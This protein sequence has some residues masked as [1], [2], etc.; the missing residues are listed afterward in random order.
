M[1]IKK[2]Y[3]SEYVDKKIRKQRTKREAKLLSLVKKLGIPVPSIYDLDML[4]FTLILEYIE[5]EILRDALLS[6]ALDKKKEEEIFRQ[7]GRYVGIMHK[8]NVIHGDLTTS[9]IILTPVGKLV[10]IDFGLGSISTSIEDKGIELR[11][12]Y[13][14]LNSKHYGKISY[15]FQA[16]LTGYIETYPGSESIIRK[17]HEISRRGRYVATRRLRK[18]MPP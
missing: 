14:S 11:V 10:F 4:N 1:R 15:L 7:I 13:T 17:F 18:I 16:F 2:E 5:G 6:N 9:N 8:A 12:F 3:R